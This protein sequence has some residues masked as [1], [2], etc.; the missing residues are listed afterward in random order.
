MESEVKGLLGR[1]Q[2]EFSQSKDRLEQLRHERVD[3]YRGRQDRLTLFEQSC[4]KLK[5][6]WA[7]RLEALK[8]AFGERVKVTPRLATGRRQATFSFT[9]DLARIMLTFSATTDTDVRSL[10]LEYSLEILPVLMTFPDH[11]RLEQPLEKIDP[12]AI[13]G[14][15][16]DRIVEVVRTYLSLHE[17]EFYLKSHMTEDPIA[18]VRFPTFA[19]A[20]TLE[21]G[22]KTLYFMANETR[23]EY[24]ARE[25]G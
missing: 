1:I 22:G 4:E 14:W 17:N 20:A 25:A 23:D 24:L 13:G 19:A 2:A 6:V 3:E 21:R 18:Q 11:A 9:S 16:D 10:I 5:G 15:I 8:E 7:P 12:E